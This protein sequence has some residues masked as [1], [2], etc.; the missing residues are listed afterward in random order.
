MAVRAAAYVCQL[1]VPTIAGSKLLA[2]LATFFQGRAGT[3]TDPRGPPVLLAIFAGGH[4]GGLAEHRTEVA[5]VGKA[6]SIRD[7]DQHVVAIQQQLGALHPLI[8]HIAVGRRVEGIGEG[9]EELPRT[10]LNERRKIEQ[11]QLAI[12]I[13]SNVIH[14][15]LRLEP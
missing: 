11:A 6:E 5:L 14:H 2:D 1:A 10:E 3:N 9:P 8:D 7:V 12:E 13:C 15:T 4:S